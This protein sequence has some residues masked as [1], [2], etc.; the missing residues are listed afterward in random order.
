M[1]HPQLG[2]AAIKWVCELIEESPGPRP[3]IDE[4]IAAIGENLPEDI[5]RSYRRK[6]PAS[7][8]LKKLPIKYDS[9]PAP[10]PTAFDE[11]LTAWTKLW[12]KSIN[13][14]VD[15]H[16]ERQRVARAYLEEIKK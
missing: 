1:T 11:Q 6:F 15:R 9:V 3:S 5:R 4:M 2:R 10:K 13:Q 8:L 14:A 16:R 7:P 12:V